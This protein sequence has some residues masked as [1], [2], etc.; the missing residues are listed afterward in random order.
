MLESSN[1]ILQPLIAADRSTALPPQHS[2]AL[3]E[4]SSTT[5]VAVSALSSTSQTTERGDRKVSSNFASSSL[6]PMENGDS[7][8]PGQAIK[9]GNKVEINPEI[10]NLA[11]QRF[12]A[13]NKAVEF[14][15]LKEVPDSED[16]KHEKLPSYFNTVVPST[17]I[18]TLNNKKKV[19]DSDDE[20]DS[21]E[22]MEKYINTLIGF[23]EGVNFGRHET[24]VIHGKKHALT[25]AAFQKN[26]SL[27]RKYTRELKH[28]LKTEGIVI[29]DE[30]LGTA[31]GLDPLPCTESLLKMSTNFSAMRHAQNLFVSQVIAPSMPAQTVRDSG[32][33]VVIVVAIDNDSDKKRK[34]EKK[35][36][37][38]ILTK[39]DNRDRVALILD[40]KTWESHDQ[41]KLNFPLTPMTK[42]N[43]ERV[44]SILDNKREAAT[45]VLHSLMGVFLANLSFAN[46]DKL[47]TQSKVTILLT[48]GGGDTNRAAEFARSFKYIRELAGDA[49]LSSTL[50][51]IGVG[52]NHE[53]GEFRKG[54]EKLARSNNG[55][56]FDVSNV[57]ECFLSTLDRVKSQC[58]VV[59]LSP[60]T[61]TEFTSRGWKLVEVWHEGSGKPVIETSNNSNGET[62]YKVSQLGLQAIANDARRTILYKFEHLNNESK[63]LKVNSV[64]EG[65]ILLDRQPFKMLADP[66]I[67]D[68]FSEFDQETLMAAS[69]FVYQNAV[70]EAYTCIEEFFKNKKQGIDYLKQIDH[71]LTILESAQRKL[72]IACIR[73]KISLLAIIRGLETERQ[74]LADLQC[75]PWRPEIFANQMERIFKS[76]HERPRHFRDCTSAELG[77]S[78]MAEKCMQLGV[79]SNETQT[80]TEKLCLDMMNDP[81]ILKDK[82]KVLQDI[83]SLHYGW[84]KTISSIM[85]EYR[86]PEPVILFGFSDIGP[87][88]IA[89]TVQLPPQSSENTMMPPPFHFDLALKLD[90][91]DPA[92]DCLVFK[93]DS[94]LLSDQLTLDQ[95][96]S[97]DWEKLLRDQT[98]KKQK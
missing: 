22:P 88:Y 65:T 45:E 33:D 56:Y 44:L 63:T 76:K 53:H 36:I 3:I 17:D 15:D 74:M 24:R 8:T 80:N 84:P 51:T 4:Q 75:I 7:K 25:L 11:S 54:L 55:D 91:K 16:K 68:N 27:E 9:V 41:K 57:P 5:N 40:T 49:A 29:K 73:E 13:F 78:R 14:K 28:Y 94:K 39:L 31:F 61:T 12:G 21:D 79:W 18:P 72:P 77:A 26:N 93:D 92:K 95:L 48:D 81:E 87:Q 85:D 83:L 35:A 38:G 96:L 50:F 69:N 89:L 64:L 34:D 86:L 67:L 1:R 32:I 20:A 97:L 70:D 2:P 10:L 37:Q 52:L 66:V 62:I 19:S 59:K 43:K 6:I 82:Q 90:K 47:L 58:Q 46:Q 60:A 71:A 98:K 23:Y 42:E 30:L